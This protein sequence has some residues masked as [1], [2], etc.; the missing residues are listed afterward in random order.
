MRRILLLFVAM[1]GLSWTAVAQ[2]IN[3]GLNLSF[4]PGTTLFG[5]SGRYEAPIN[6]DF[7]WMVTPGVQF[8]GGA[9]LIFIQGGAKYTLQEAPVYF[10]AEL[11]PVIGSGG[12]YSETKFGFTPSVGYRVDDQW[13]LSFQLYAGA[14]S[15][16]VGFR[17]AYVFSKK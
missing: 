13:D 11:G 7:K 4:P 2:E 6:N 9:T 5:F 1:V 15:T 10:G 12:G 17:F 14:W 8:G 3:G 16:F